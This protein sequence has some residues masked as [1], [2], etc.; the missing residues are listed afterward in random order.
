MAKNVANTLVWHARKGMLTGIWS[1]NKIV[2][3]MNIR[4][5]VP[6]NYSN[7]LKANVKA[8]INARANINSARKNRALGALNVLFNKKPVLRPEPEPE[9]NLNISTPNINTRQRQ[10]PKRNNNNNLRTARQHRESFGN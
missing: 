5:E 2:N 8:K 9:G 10:A 4:R 1:P 3:T 7:A 6:T